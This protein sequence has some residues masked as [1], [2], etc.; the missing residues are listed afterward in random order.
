MSQ[1]HPLVVADHLPFFVTAPG[2]TDELF[3]PVAVTLAAI[4]I[5][6]LVTPLTEIARALEERRDE[7][8]GTNGTLT[9]FKLKSGDIVNPILRPADILVFPQG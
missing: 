6:D 2:E 3:G 5:P 1:A 7:V 8:A 4:R 9:Q